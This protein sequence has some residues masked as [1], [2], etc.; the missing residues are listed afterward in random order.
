MYYFS[1]SIIVEEGGNLMNTESE[2]EEEILF[3]SAKKARRLNGSVPRPAN[4][5]KEAFINIDV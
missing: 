2:S 4:G 1:D 3:E 5:Y